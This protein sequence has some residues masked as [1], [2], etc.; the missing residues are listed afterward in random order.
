[1]AHDWPWPD[2]LGALIAAPEQHRLLLENVG[3][4]MLH[5]ISTEVK[6]VSLLG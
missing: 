3:S 6:P 5:I 4:V 1:M 2:S